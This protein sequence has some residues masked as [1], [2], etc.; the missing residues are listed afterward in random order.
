M[1]KTKDAYTLFIPEP[2]KQTRPGNHQEPL[3]FESFQNE[4]LCVVHC[5]EEYLKRTD[6]IRENLQGNPKDLFLSYTYPHNPIGK[7]TLTRYI[8]DFMQDA[9]IDITVYSNHSLRKSST[10]KA[11]NM[12]LCIKDIQK[13]AGWKSDN[14]F[15]RH[16]KLPILKNFG[17]TLLSGFQKS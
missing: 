3:R 13:A 7:A 8:K 14:S 12:G 10:S 15:R 2:V 5:L 4:K 16:Y 9:G 1:S 6:L 17:N 11:N